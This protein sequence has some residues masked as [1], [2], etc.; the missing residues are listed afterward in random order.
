M[1]LHRYAMLTFEVPLPAVEPW[2]FVT[3]E[4]V[5]VSI[6]SFQGSDLPQPSQGDGPSIAVPYSLPH[7]APTQI[8]LHAQISTTYDVV[9]PF[10]IQLPSEPREAAERGLQEMAGILGILGESS[11]A[12]SSP[13]PYLMLSAETGADEEVIHATK[14]IILPPPTMAPAFHGSGLRQPLNV[15]GLLSD[16]PDGVLLLG[17]AMRAGGGVAKLHELFRVMENGF[18]RA[19]GGL[20]LPLTEFLQSYPAWN[21]GYTSNEI[22]FWVDDLRNPATHADLRRSTRVAYDTDVEK[23]LYRIEQAA[24]D[25][26][27]NKALWGRSSTGRI[28]RWVFQAA[29]QADGHT[30]LSNGGLLRSNIQNDH[31]GTFPLAEAIHLQIGD[32][33]A[34]WLAADWHFSEADWELFEDQKNPSA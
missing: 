20:V 27:F 8:L 1:L 7:R 4:G 15:A 24:Y 33:P 9:N 3:R 6:N 23:Y 12:I 10:Q 32:L 11:W 13:R 18:G 26:L 21:L 2:G 17:A 14:R 29:R 34:N 25:V 19:G 30:I 31:F 5:E 22:R 16:R 28:S